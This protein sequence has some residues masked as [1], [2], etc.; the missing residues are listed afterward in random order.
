MSSTYSE[1]R[2]EKRSSTVQ[3][4]SIRHFMRAFPL[5][6]HITLY[7][8]SLLK[9]SLSTFLLR[10]TTSER[11]KSR[12]QNRTC[13]MARDVKDSHPRTRG[14][15][16][17]SR[18]APAVHTVCSLFEATWP[19]SLGA[20]VG[21]LFSFEESPRGSFFLPLWTLKFISVFWAAFK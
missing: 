4:G 20:P 7:G 15:G 12:E 14:K 18:V 13:H 16:P 6:V 19:S 17:S 1:A 21:Q 11:R 5:H 8:A 2:L 10:K 9:T 3:K